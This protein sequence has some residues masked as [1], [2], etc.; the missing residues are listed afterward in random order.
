MKSPR[1]ATPTR[2]ESV[3]TEAGL[4]CPVCQRVPL[5]GRRSVCS[6]ACQ[7]RRHRLGREQARRERAAELRELLEAAL[8]RLDGEGKS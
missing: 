8:R 4:L 3:R 5:Q 2:P 1:P 7:A 6:P